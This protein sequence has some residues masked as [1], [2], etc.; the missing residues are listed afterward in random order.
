MPR[1]RNTLCAANGKALDQPGGGRGE[2][3]GSRS[4]PR[5]AA[6]AA[7][8]AVHAWQR[9]VAPCLCVPESRIND[10][11]A[12]RMM[13]CPGVGTAEQPIRRQFRHADWSAKPRDLLAACK[14]P[15]NRQFPPVRSS[16]AYSVRSTTR[17]RLPILGD[18]FSSD[19]RCT[20]PGEQVS[21]QPERFG[22]TSSKR[23][24]QQGKS[25]R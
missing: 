2:T 11:R 5:I 13:P 3:P 17:S 15:H 8:S 1:G 23:Y 24:G 25:C 4:E 7:Q 21:L 12:R 16:I 9:R 20:G 10:V 22:T 6:H 14:S 19:S 18:E